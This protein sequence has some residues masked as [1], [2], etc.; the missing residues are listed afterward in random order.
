MKY[1]RDIDGLRA[2]AILLVLL[3][4]GGL[5]VFPSGFVGVDVFF[6]ISGFLI[7]SI[8]HN[9]L[10]DNNFSFVDFY[11]R[12]LWRLQ[13]VFISLIV[14]TFLLSFVLFLPDDLIRYNESALKTALLMSNVYFQKTT[15]EYFSPDSHMLPLL[16]TWS[17]SIEW[18]CYLLLPLVI[19]CLHKLF[20]STK[21]STS[22][23]SNSPRDVGEESKP[24]L[25]MFVSLAVFCLAYAFYSSAQEPLQS[26][27][28][29]SSRIFEFL[30]GSCIALCPLKA[31]SYNKVL[32]NAAGIAALML[33]VYCACQDNILSGYPNGYAL[34]VCLST[35]LLIVLGGLMPSHLVGRILTLQPLVFIGVLSYS[36]Y[37]WHWVVFA[38]LRYENVQE[39]IKVLIAAYSLSFVL[40][41][42]SWKF[43]EKPTRRFNKMPFSYTLIGLVLV[44]IAFMFVS[45]QFMKYYSGFPQRFNQDLVHIYDKLNDYSS[46]QRPLCVSKIIKNTKTVC[47]LGIHSPEAKKAFL[48]GDSFANHYWGFV[49]TL[50]KNAHVSVLT[51]ATSA[52]ITLPGIYL[53]DWWYFTKDVYQECH[54]KTAEYYRMIK[55]NHYD[56][57]LIGQVWP[58]YYSTSIINKL[59]DKQAIDLSQQRLTDAL[60]EALKII[61][62]SGARPVLIKAIAHEDEHARDCVFHYVKIRKPYNPDTCSF[63]LS[64]SEGELWF[65]KLFK[66]MQQK[67]PQLVV[68]DPKQVQCPDGLCRADIEGVPVY[69]DGGHITDYASYK[70]GDLYLAHMGNPLLIT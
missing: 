28:F 6:V 68:I 13:P 18:Q 63:A 36:L 19:Y 37:I 35:C 1:R 51:Q 40:A 25:F 15:T 27:Y 47:S 62:S 23:G 34:L 46:S 16:H 26:Y 66:Q 20:V 52:C 5:A 30:L 9:S 48:I 41:F 7:T 55:K 59:G 8:I 65:D 32:L 39:S 50:A 22:R 12:R 33:I 4:H 43:L 10:N 3:Y 53:Y 67:Y 31:R 21:T 24:L 44:P 69:R 17:L 56:Y 61:I 42:L 58:N 54:D 14:I 60:E 2:V 38:V 11:S 45:V 57:V 29:F 49:D 64:K 70:F